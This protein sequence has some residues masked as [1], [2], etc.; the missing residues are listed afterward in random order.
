MAELTKSEFKALEQRASQEDL[1]NLLALL[2]EDGE[3][4]I[5]DD[6][7]EDD[8]P[9]DAEADLE[10]GLWFPDVLPPAEDEPAEN[11]LA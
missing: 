1:K 10:A 7:S 8:E 9:E 2:K 4:F 3:I 6:P 11:G 5:V